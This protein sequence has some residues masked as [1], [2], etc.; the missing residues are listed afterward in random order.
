MDAQW[1]AGGLIRGDR[2][3]CAGFLRKNKSSYVYILRRPDGRPFYVGKGEGQRVF[4][5]ENEARHPNGRRSNAH[6]LNV[7]RAVWQSGQQ[8]GYEIDHVCGHGGEAYLREAELITLWGR[9]HEG[10]P[11]TNLAPGG[12]SDLG[13][14]PI[15]KDKHSATLSGAP[16]DNPKERLSIGLS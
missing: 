8:V 4:A 12:G 5:H 11:L 2:N 3:A 15:S 16:E 6:K 7:I 9:L 14:S 10:G 13:A 1:P